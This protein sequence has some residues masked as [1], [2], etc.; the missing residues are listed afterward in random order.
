VTNV[1]KYLLIG[2]VPRPMSYNFNSS[3]NCH[4]SFMR[5]LVWLHRTC[6]LLLKSFIM[7]MVCLFRQCFDKVQKVYAVIYIIKRTMQNKIIHC[8]FMINVKV[9]GNRLQ[10]AFI[11]ATD[12]SKQKCL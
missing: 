6:Q 3:F 8:M 10:Q 2:M 4:C 5:L 11:I 9:D 12:T 1:L 7:M